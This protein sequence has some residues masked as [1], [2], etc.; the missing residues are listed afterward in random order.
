MPSQA[1]KDMALLANL[2]PGE[3]APSVDAPPANPDATWYPKLNPTQD[4]IFNDPRRFILAY[5]ERGSGK[6]IDRQSLVWTRRGLERL[7]HLKGGAPDPDGFC[8]LRRETKV[9]AFDEDA[10]LFQPKL[11]TD[12]YEESNPEARCL[13][14]SHGV[15]FK[16][17]PI[18]P[19]WSECD[20]VFKYRPAMEIQAL[21][22]EGRRV[23]TPIKVGHD[24]W[25]NKELVTVRHSRKPHKGRD[26]TRKF[27]TVLTED[28][29]YAL[30]CL[31]G[32]GNLT[33]VQYAHSVEFTSD[34]GEL[35]T[36]LRDALAGIPDLEVA[37][38]GENKHS[39]YIFTSLELASLIT[40]LGM[41]ELAMF[42]S[43]PVEILSSPRPVAAAFVRGMMDTDGHAS[44]DGTCEFVTV[45]PKLADDM[46][47]L[48]LALG[49]FSVKNFAF[50]KDNPGKWVLK[51]HGWQAANYYTNVGFGLERKQERRHNLHPK[52][53]VKFS[54]PPS[55]CDRLME[56][57]KDKSRYL[58]PKT[59]S[60]VR[61]RMYLGRRFRSTGPVLQDF[62]NDYQCSD[63]FAEFFPDGDC[64]WVE[65]ERVVA[66]RC[67][68]ADLVVPGLHSFVA[69]GL[70]NHNTIGALHKAVRHA[71]ENFNALVL[72]VVGVKR[73]A[74][75]G[76]AWYK[77]LTDILPQ[78]EQGLG[79]KF[80]DS[81]SNEAKDQYVF[82]SNRYGG[83]SKFLLVSM[84]VS[85][86]V[87]D[88]AKGLEPS[89]IL[90]DE[91][92]TLDGPAYFDA[93]IQQLGRRPGIN[94]P[95][96]YVMCCNPD[97]PS[98]WV[99]KRFWEQSVGEDGKLKPEYARY[100]VPIAENEPN[101]PE[102]YYQN[103]LEAVKHDE[104]EYKRMVL[105]EWV[106]R[107]TGDAIFLG[108]FNPALHTRG[109]RKRGLRLLPDPRY[110]IIVGYD[111]GSANSAIIFLQNIITRDKML[112]TCFDEM[113]YIERRYPLQ[114]IVP[115]L[116]RRMDFW[117]R[118]LDTSFAFQHISDAS[119]FNHMQN[120]SGSYEAMEV[121]RIY[122]ENNQYFDLPAMTLLPC[123]KPPH[124]VAARV[125]L[126]Q[127]LLAQERFYVSASCK[128]VS[129]MFMH[130][131][132]EKPRLNTYDPMRPLTP[133]RS[134]HLHPFD[135]LT[136][137]IFY[138]E[139]DGSRHIIST[140][141][142][143]PS[144]VKIG[145]N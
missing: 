96:Q 19:L 37:Q 67:A 99:Y 11:A 137:P 6:C 135:A 111:L 76:G 54:S 68:L 48:L 32:D 87:T 145:A 47:N 63:Q 134:R 36:D 34:Q 133:K 117:N 78:W 13:Y 71:Y 70:V 121:E 108:Y 29:A 98:H 122:R 89:F 77:L 35:V 53:P 31:C 60:C 85:S 20:G 125:R 83:W 141:R 41:D 62:I 59:R 4:T 22:A 139:G 57:W 40:A 81:K 84:P 43:I 72:I 65:C 95:Q 110:P 61:W 51:I 143:T 92:Q 100:H 56:V 5:G 74:T 109:D 126:L 28:I 7:E 23:F 116:M 119:A 2:A 44:E 103:V 127:G 1:E 10:S 52:A 138:M 130:L 118:A 26:L 9:L 8:K 113:V 30:G 123:P 88:R 93:L 12:Y 86:F 18:H 55:V 90:V 102:G 107:P 69:R 24:G 114:L 106:D 21:L 58:V 129:D 94:G 16:I 15:N 120:T 128:A 50:T 144:V 42:K 39:S 27:K 104:I 136:Y 80:T 105:G 17:S 124:S 33:R 91:G 49:V 38:K 45:S 46:H 115:E 73:Q 66:T 131:E 132:S 112:W 75:E 101:L 97:G 14:L 64:V 79:V 82:M 140:G 25:T 142:A 3:E